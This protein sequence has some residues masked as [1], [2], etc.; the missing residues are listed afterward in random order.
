[1][2]PWIFLFFFSIQAVAQSVPIQ[3]K[4]ARELKHEV[5]VTLK[6]IQ[7][8]VTDKAGN[9]V[10]DLNKDDFKIYDKKKLQKIT[11]FERYALI[12]QKDKAETQPPRIINIPAE[13]TTDIMSRKFFFFFDL[14]NNNTKGFLKSQ[15]AALHFV[16]T[17]LQP[18]D[19]VGIISYSV[20]KQLTLHEYLTTDRQA[21]RQ[22]VEGIGG[23]G[24][25]GRA[26]N[27]EAL[28][29]SL[30]QTP[31]DFPMIALPCPEEASFFCQN[32]LIRLEFRK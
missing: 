14:A 19:E 4:K 1:M 13:E 26:E 7:V 29:R 15:Q 5:A 32:E 9:P 23:M 8:Y 22:V 2:V 12:P 3:E 28:K 24:R 17:Q 31:V 30:M 18:S 6:L 16:N 25:V 10:T 20:L 11:E 21:I 27:F